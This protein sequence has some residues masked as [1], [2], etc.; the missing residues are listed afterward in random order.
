M[1]TP[2]NNGGITDLYEWAQ[3]AYDLTITFPISEKIN[4]KDI[5]LTLTPLKFKLKHRDNDIFEGEFPFSI[6]VESSVWFIENNSIIIE[7]DKYK[8]HEWWKT[9]FVGQEEIDTSKVVPASETYSD[10]D[11]STRSTIDKMLYEQ[12]LKRNKQFNSI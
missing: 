8:K 4:R 12:E 3:T 1:A 6:K 9:A 11:S 5:S 2:I 10:L 7:V